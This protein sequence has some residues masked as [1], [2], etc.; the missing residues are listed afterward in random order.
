[1]KETDFIGRIDCD[2]PYDHPLKW[3]R[4]SAAAPRISPNAAFM[5]LHEVCRVPRSVQMDRPRAE[6]IIGHLLRRFRHPAVKVIA[7]A[8]RSYISENTLRPRAA[9]SLMRKLSIYDGEYNALAICY[10][11]AYDSSGMLDRTYEQIVGRWRA[12]SGE[13]SEA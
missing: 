3:R 8:I 13:A 9:A 1:M 5:V 11:S 4:L 6:R 2:F 7:P 12:A 10:L